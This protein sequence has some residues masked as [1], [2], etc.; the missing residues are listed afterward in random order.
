MKIAIDQVV[1]TVSPRA[2][3]H[4]GGWAYLW[5][6][7]L[8]HYFKAFN[9][10][11]DVT[12]LHNGASWEGYDVVYLDHGME[13]NGE[14]LNLFGGAQDEPAIRLRRL[15]ETEPG[16][17]C[18]LDRPMPDYGALG[19][20]RLKACSDVWR[21]VD[22]DK[23]SGLVGKVTSME[24]KDFQMVWDHLALGD[25]HTFSMYK[26]GMMVCRND[27]Q[28]LHGA[29]RRGLKSFIAPYCTHGVVKHLTLYFGNIDIRHHLMRQADPEGALDTM[30]DEYFRQ[31]KELGMESVELIETLPIENESR[32]LPK[33]GF[34]KG[35]PFAGTWAERS[36]LHQLWNIRLDQFARR[37][38]DLNITVYKHP[39]VYKNKE[40]ELD[41]E[42]MEKPQSVHLARLYY[43]WDLENDC[44]NP[45][46]VARPSK[47]K[48]KKEKVPKILIPQIKNVE[49]VSLWDSPMGKPLIEF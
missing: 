9:E 25:S 44:P 33:T 19:K 27:G 18:S 37:N 11:V 46:L 32:K 30:L 36:Q 45:N 34:Y 1:G 23:M 43:R 12:V 6:N 21:A 28:T 35:T 5:A 7:Q 48:P 13:F 10:D 4:K 16:A 14:S 38:P 42:V 17:I 31:I 29:L 8:K 20:G 24:Q 15:L 22:W 49:P 3:S 40:G 26:P 39:D 2:T 41:F 47:D